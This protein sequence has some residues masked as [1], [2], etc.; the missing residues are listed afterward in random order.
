MRVAHAAVEVQP[1]GDVPGEVRKARVVRLVN[2]IVA[3]EL[4]VQAGNDVVQDLMRRI[5]RDLIQQET[6]DG[7]VDQA[8]DLAVEAQF[9]SQRVVEQVLGAEGSRTAARRRCPRSNGCRIRGNR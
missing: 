6:A 1:F 2:R 4:K 8:A 9:L 3:Q 7:V 5:R